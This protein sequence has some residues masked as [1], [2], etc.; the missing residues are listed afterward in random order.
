MTAPITSSTSSKSTSS[1]DPLAG[2]SG[3]G[4]AMGKDQF[5]KLLVAQ[6]THQDPLNP[7]DSSQMASQLAQFSSVEQLMN[8]NSQ[9]TTQANS[10]AAVTSAITNASALSLIGKTVMV[11]DPQ[12]AVGGTDATLNVSADIPTAGGKL[13]LT[14]KDAN[15]NTVAVRDL[16]AAT[17]GRKTFA[18]GDA[19]AG[20]TAGTYTASFSLTDGTGAVTNPPAISSVRVD[21]VTYGPSGASITSGGRTYS[22]GSVMQVFSTN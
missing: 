10:N 20:L 18:L 21:G 16:G 8:I 15:G 14:I 13:T 12:I 4:G 5:I 3:A 2:L 6:L 11:Q 17:S 9:L 1:S 22:I 7:Q 19:T